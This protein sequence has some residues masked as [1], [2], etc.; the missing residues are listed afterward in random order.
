MAIAGLTVKS[1]AKGKAS[2]H[3]NYVARTGGYERY[4]ERGEVLEASAHGNMPAWATHDPSAFWKASDAYERANGSSYRE[5]Q[6][7][8]PRELSPDQRR[9]LV[10]QFVTQEIGNTHAYQ[11]VSYTH[12]TLPTKA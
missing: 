7:S 6:I 1:G 3:A 4:L 2:A 9:E 5:F 11:S 10:E 8:L 12:L